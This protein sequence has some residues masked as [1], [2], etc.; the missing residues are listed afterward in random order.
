MKVETVGEMFRGEVGKAM[1]SKGRFSR[2]IRGGVVG[3]IRGR[4]LKR[5]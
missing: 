5:S 3:K 4:K 2:E 1:G